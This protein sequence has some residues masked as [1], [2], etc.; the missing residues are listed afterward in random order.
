MSVFVGQL[1]ALLGI[2]RTLPV[3]VP[4]EASDDSNIAAWEL[5]AWL[6]RRAVEQLTLATMTLSSLS[7]L[8]GKVNNMVI[9]DYIADEVIRAV[10]ASQTALDRLAGGHFQEAFAASKQALVSSERAFFDPSLLELLYFSDDQKYA[11]YVPLFLPL[12]VSILFG[13]V[14]GFRFVLAARKKAKTE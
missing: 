3:L 12:G 1:R 7:D 10:E 11:I 2:S 14:K 5:Q 4:I 6:R 9:K 8:L 13:F